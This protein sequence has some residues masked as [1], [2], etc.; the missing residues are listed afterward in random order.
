MVIKERFNVGEETIRSSEGS[1]TADH[2]DPVEVFPIRNPQQLDASP[3][4]FLY[5]ATGRLRELYPNEVV[6]C[7]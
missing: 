1:S 3:D 7:S 2:F 6:E 4:R 5:L